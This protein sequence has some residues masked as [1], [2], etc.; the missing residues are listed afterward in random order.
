MKAWSQDGLNMC[1]N[2]KNVFIATTTPTL[3]II[4]LKT[5]FLFYKNNPYSIQYE[6][7]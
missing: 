1:T 4:A 6:L 3:L 5:A 7:N 2:Y